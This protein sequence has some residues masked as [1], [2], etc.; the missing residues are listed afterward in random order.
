[1]VCEECVEC[2]EGLIVWFEII[3]IEVF[4]NLDI[5]NDELC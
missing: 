4:G 3:V 2:F 1:M 5:V